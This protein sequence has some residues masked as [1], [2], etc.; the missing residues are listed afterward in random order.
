MENSRCDDDRHY[1]AEAELTYF[2][3]SR[4]TFLKVSG[5][6]VAGLF[7]PQAFPGLTQ[8]GDGV[9]TVDIVEAVAWGLQDAGARTVTSVPATGVAALFDACHRLTG[10]NP[11]YAFNEELAYTMACGAALAGTRAATII[12]SHGFAKAA[13]SVIDSLTLGTT[14]G[15]VAVVIDD[16]LGAHSDSV[17]DLGMFLK[18]TGIPFKRAEIGTVYQALIESFL[19]SEELRTPVALLLDSRLMSKHTVCM[20]RPLAPPRAHYKR[21]PMRHVLCPPLA[22]YQQ[23]VYETRRAR[24]DWRNVPKP[25]MPPIPEGLPPAWRSAAAQYVPLFDVFQELRPQIPFVCGDTGLSSLFAFAPYACVDACSYYGG[26]LPMAIGA[27]LGGI[28]RPW[29]VTGDYA[30]LA[31]GH[32][33]LIEAMAR[34][35]PLKVLV[36]ENGCAMATGGQPI[37]EGI[38]EQVLSGWGAF[39]SRIEDPRNAAEV[40]RLLDRALHSE[41]IEIVVARMRG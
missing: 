37:P 6:A 18:G 24:G 5:L 3:K 23:K 29:A 16:P 11:P 19:W 36:V 25:V 22:V 26:S 17:F 40:R 34:R 33:G 7:L 27:H 2:D 9:R 41:R 14:A 8:A 12:K 21:D 10:K 15:F 1:M 30:F 4:R 28:D 20:R 35:V 13:N 38:F 31:A 32:M 39:V